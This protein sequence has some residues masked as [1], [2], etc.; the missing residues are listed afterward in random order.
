MVQLE[1]CQKAVSLGTLTTVRKVSAGHYGLEQI[2]RFEVDTGDWRYLMEAAQL[3]ASVLEGKCSIIKVGITSVYIYKL[4]GPC[5]SVH[6][7]KLTEG[8]LYDR[9]TRFYHTPQLCRTINGLTQN[10]ESLS[11]PQAVTV[12]IPPSLQKL[13][14]SSKFN[15]LSS[16]WRL[17]LHFVAPIEFPFQRTWK[18][19]LYF[20]GARARCFTES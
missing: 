9:E 18:H 15:T 12:L 4:Q 19:G 7:R 6:T 2:L 14:S 5:N 11:R 10:L 20:S 16:F 3:W 13:D 17:K 8:E 1:Y